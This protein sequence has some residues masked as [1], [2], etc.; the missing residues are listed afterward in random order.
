MFEAATG[1][2]LATLDTAGPR[3]SVNGVPARGGSL[4]SGALFAGGGM[5]FA[6]SGYATFGQPAGNALIAYRPG[7]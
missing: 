5:V 1:K 2:V 3:D 4:D 6:G 7:P